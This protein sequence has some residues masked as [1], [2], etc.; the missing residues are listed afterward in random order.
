MQLGKKSKA[1]DIYE[2]VRGDFGHEAEETRPVSHAATSSVLAGDK[3][4]LP[5]VPPATDREPI[6]ITV[7]ETISAKLSREG[8]LKSFEIKGDLKL[9][10]SDPSFTKIKLELT[11]NPTHGAQFRTHPNVDKALFTKEK[12]IQPKDTSKPFPVY[13]SIGVLRWRV[14]GSDDTE[15]LPITFTV[16]VNRG[17]ET[18]S[19]TVEYELTGSDSLQ[20]VIVTIPFGT[21]E[22]IVTSFDATYEVTGDSIDWNIGFVDDSNPSGSFEFESSDSNGDENEFFPMSVRFSKPTPSVD[23][24]VLAVSLLEMEGELVNFSKDIKSIAEGYLIE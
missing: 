15:I 18:T 3:T 5:H 22:P 24:S 20:D 7:F 19:V 21:V 4:S 2:K 8:A 16:W 23:V 10:I 14:A 17:S 6:H 12:A 13:N 1:T 11:A 9:R